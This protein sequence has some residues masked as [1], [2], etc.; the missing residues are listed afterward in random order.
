MP[1]PSSEP[2][3]WPRLLMKVVAVTAALAAIYLLIAN[4]VLAAEL[5]SLARDPR[6]ELRHGAAYTLIPGRIHVE[7][8]QI[9]D[10]ERLD[11]MAGP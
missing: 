6:I 5:R 1:S 11:A 2:R 9:G 8:L 7:D 3:R 10:R 4:A